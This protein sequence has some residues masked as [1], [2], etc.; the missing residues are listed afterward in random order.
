MK[1]FF[2]KKEDWDHS[3][4]SIWAEG[5]TVEQ[6]LEVAKR[7]DPNGDCFFNG[8]VTDNGLIC[9]DVLISELRMFAYDY[10]SLC[11]GLSAEIRGAVFYGYEDWE[12]KV[13]YASKNGLHFTNYTIRTDVA[14]Y[15]DDTSYFEDF[16]EDDFANLQEAQIF[17]WEFTVKGENGEDLFQIGGNDF[18]VQ[19]IDNIWNKN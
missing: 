15:I 14:P 16:G 3:Y 18:S 12:E 13:L 6:I 2:G 7:I 11:S 1:E 19:E 5:A 10:F 17:Y 9:F 8:E 4:A